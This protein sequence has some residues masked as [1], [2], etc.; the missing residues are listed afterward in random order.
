MGRLL[1]SIDTPEDLK[2]M[3]A[4][5]LPGLAEEIRQL[6]V[7]TVSNT[8]GH[9]A[10]NLGAVE[11][12]LALHRVF[13]T[14][15][16]KIVWDV[17]HQA[18]VHKILTGRKDR[19]D[20]LRQ[21]S[22]ISGFPKI[23]ESPYD[24]FGVGHASTSISA[25]L[26]MA[27]ARDMKGEQFHVVAVIGDGALTGGIAFEGL[28]NAGG[29]R[30]N[31]IVVLNDNRMSIAPNVGAL[32]KALTQVIT[33]PLYNRLKKDIWNLTGKLPRGTGTVRKLVQRLEE[34]LKAMIVP[35]LLFERFGFRYVGPVE[36]HE[37]HNLIRIFQNLRE[38]RGPILVH[39]LTTKGKGYKFAEED[40][41]R[42]HGLGSFCPETGLPKPNA[43]VSYTEAFGKTVVELARQDPRVVGITAA[44]AH[45]TGLIHLAKAFPD[46]FFDVGIA[47]QHAVTFAAGMALEG[48]RPIVAIYSTFLQRA[49]DQVIHDVALQKIPVILALDRGGLVGEDGPTHHGSFDLSYLRLIPD[50][51]L[52][53]PKDISEL[54]HM[55]WTALTYQDGPVAIRYP[56]GEGRGLL[57]DEPFQ[58]IPL[59]R[60]EVIREGVDA[61]I[62]AVG[63]Q[64]PTAEK[65]A[66]RLLEEG[67]S[68]EV[69]NMRF[70]KPID[71]TYIH[72]AVKR[73]GVIVTLENNTVVGGLGGAVAETLA[74]LRAE[75]QFRR[76]GLPD[77]FVSHGNTCRLFSE[78]GLDVESLSNA[79]RVLCEK[80]RT[81]KLLPFIKTISRIP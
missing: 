60:C 62:L 2:K 28:N 23:S 80:R 27:T 72:T 55:L 8:G 74:E 69:V 30:R 5:D 25:A 43:S 48:F 46:R 9:L 4:A 68:A 73:F 59:G 10:P 31:L 1:D 50:I 54:R 20:T 35:A 17:G 3:D 32:P 56:R 7:R 33:T 39:V 45:G 21:H 57:H 70:V 38:F 34:G 16:D 37:V 61:S 51:V 47:E 76:F 77:Q 44:M 22:G 18:Y 52:M 75:V 12:T 40:A 19:F 26:G 11:L 65:V 63:D 71:H 41:T 15:R 78:M 29:A 66:E 49:F 14:P 13:D 67:I 24:A 79:I 64:V 58:E 81:K 42:F 6:L 53:A 36:G